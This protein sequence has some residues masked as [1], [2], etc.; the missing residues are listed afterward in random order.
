MVLC[1][2]GHG[3]SPDKYGR[4]RPNLQLL[5]ASLAKMGAVVFAYDMIGF[6]ECTTYRH[7]DPKAVQIQT[8]NSKRILDYMLSLDYTDAE[9]VGITGSSGGGTQSFLLTALDDRVTVSVPVVQVSAHFFGGCT[10]E[11]GMP[12]HKSKNHETNNVEIAALAAPRP[13]LLI[14]DGEDWTKNTPEVEFPYIQR[15]YEFYGAGDKVQNVHLADEGHDYGSSKRKATYKFMAE[16]LGLNYE[17][18]LN[19]NGEVD[20]DF[21]TLQ[22]IQDLKVFPEQSIVFLIDWD[23]NLAEL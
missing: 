22:A 5:C 18:I 9:N 2:H 7:T 11:S 8:F 21:V 10:C 4:F 13:M 3:F 23:Y 20:E 19:G 14:S 6:G 1:P 12:I 17:E 16:Y 15:I